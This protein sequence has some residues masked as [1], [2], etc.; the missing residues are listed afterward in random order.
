MHEKP[1]NIKDVAAEA[2]C[3][4]ATV[5]CVLNDRGRIGKA[6][7]KRVREACKKLNYFPSSAGRNLRSRKTE[8]IGILFYPS[9]AHIFHNVFYSEIMVGLEEQL[10]EA[11]QNLLL[12]GYDI[13]IANHQEELPKFIREG[14]VDGVILMGGCP[15]DFKQKVVEVNLPF[16]LLDTDISGVSVDSVISD[17]FRA[18]IAMVGYI[19]SKG[20]RKM[21]M[22]RHK[23]DNYNEISRCMGFE[24]E[25]RRLGIEA[26]V[27]RVATN[28]EATQT[29]IDRIGTDNP[30]TAV[31]TVNDDMAAD[32][33]NKLMAAGINVPEQVSITGFDD[34]EF[35]R[36]THPPLTTIHIDR[37]QM[38]V[39][40]AK[41]ILR[42]ISDREAPLRKLVIS[43]ELIKR[44]SVKQL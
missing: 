9:C 7:Q 2:K 14:S 26:D 8:S 18:M 28:D 32:I 25:T 1:T 15:D 36:E 35:S 44:N 19:H 6:T 31:C 22:V 42:R 4:I 41:T 33:M 27:I 20:H 13:S 17:G 16:L 5:S 40:G 23:Y 39:E 34:T 3:S 12:A 37:K 24:A 30:V 21:M 43:S 38:G 10:T 11:N 29:I